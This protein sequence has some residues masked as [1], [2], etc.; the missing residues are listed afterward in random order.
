M[1]RRSVVLK[2]GPLFYGLGKEKLQL[3]TQLLPLLPSNHIY[4]DAPKLR[5]ALD[6]DGYLYFKNII[7]KD[8]IA[9]AFNDI[10]DQL[11]QNGWVRPE[12]RAAQMEESGFTYGCPFP[13]NCL[14][15][16]HGGEE[17]PLP[18]P[19]VGFA[20]TEAIQKAIAG[21]NMT[22]L[23]RQILSGQ[24][25]CLPQRTLELSKPGEVHGFHMDRPYMA[26]GTPLLLTA[27]IPLQHIPVSLGG[28]AVGRGSN[29]EDSFKDIRHSYGQYDLLE[30]DI[31]GDG[32]YTFDPHEMIEQAKLKPPKPVSKSK[33]N[34]K[35]SG[36]VHGPK[37]INP[38]RDDE[39][40]DEEDEAIARESPLLTTSFEA[41]DVV[42]TTLYTMHSFMVNQTNL[43]R[44]SAETK[45]MMEGDDIGIDKRYRGAQGFSQALADYE[46]TRDDVKKFPR[47]MEQAKKDWGLVDKEGKP[48]LKSL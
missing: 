4:H 11:I 5:V 48:C 36:G 2:H 22:T 47:S 1:L 12:D 28:L 27:W 38:G 33:D 6:R 18:D 15:K 7:P 30:G 17:A 46:M 45:W 10:G 13:K 44:L 3:G 23:I 9:D 24:V 31:H 34:D 42:V 35:S 16:S 8:V 20:V 21:T 40:D 37:T 29:S 25:V 41:G 32:S 19:K 26:Q 43:W 39:D 14:P